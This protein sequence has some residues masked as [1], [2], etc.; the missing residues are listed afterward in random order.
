VRT[1][2][3]AA[4]RRNQAEGLFK[5]VAV[6]SGGISEPVHDTDMVPIYKK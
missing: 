6:T 1:A 3:V 2:Q 4:N 5:V